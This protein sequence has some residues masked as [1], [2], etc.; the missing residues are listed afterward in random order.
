MERLN[1][2]SSIKERLK[3]V[4]KRIL[5]EVDTIIEQQEG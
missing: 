1:H 2:Y 4:R 3:N 5:I